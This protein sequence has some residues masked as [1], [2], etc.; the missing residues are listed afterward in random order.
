MAGGSP[1]TL[2]TSLNVEE[3]SNAVLWEGR[4]DGG[5][6]GGWEVGGVVGSVFPLLKIFFVLTFI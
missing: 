1:K 6:V 2:E 4:N 3:S 5:R